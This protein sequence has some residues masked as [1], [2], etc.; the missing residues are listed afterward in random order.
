MSLKWATCSDLDHAAM[1]FDKR[2]QHE[3]LAALLRQTCPSTSFHDPVTLGRCGTIP[4]SLRIL[5]HGNSSVLRPNE[6]CPSLIHAQ[7][8]IIYLFI[9]K[10]AL[11]LLGNPSE[12]RPLAGALQAE[13]AR[14]ISL[15]GS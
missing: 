7:G 3:D 15:M 8:R 11:N 13:C 10:S 4:A 6:R 1:D 14:L 5:L 2:K 12:I 9:T